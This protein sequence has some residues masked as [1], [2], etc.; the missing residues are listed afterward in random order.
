MKK[1]DKEYFYKN[2]GKGR[3]PN[4]PNNIKVKSMELQVVKVSDVDTDVVTKQ[5]RTADD[6]TGRASSLGVSFSSG[7]DWNQPLP[8]VRKREDKSLSLVDAF[9]RFE[10]F[11]VNGQKYWLMVVIECDEINELRIRGW[12]NRRLHRDESSTKDNIEA[13]SKM[14]RKG[15][16]KKSEHAYR[17]ELN[18]IEPN[19]SKEAK[20]QIIQTLIDKFGSKVTPKKKRFISY[21]ATT[22]M[23]NWVNKHYADAKRLGFKLGSKGKPLFSKIGNC[24]YGVLQKDYEARKVLQAVR[25]NLEKD[26]PLKLVGISGGKITSKKQLEKERK[27]SLRNIKKI[28]NELDD[29]YAKHGC[30]PPWHKVFIHMGFVPEDASEN[31]KELVKI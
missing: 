17:R 16:I 5:S 13:I 25:F 15:F 10:M 3:V 11:E 21:S 31:P 2:F 23:K 28:T 6:I 8:I 20:A 26:V 12:A 1:Y 24:F 27:S 30:K 14:V 9:G 19:K 4:F 22:L 18:I 7:M 29:F